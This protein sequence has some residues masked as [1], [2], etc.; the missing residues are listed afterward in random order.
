MRTNRT[1]ILN[2]LL[3]FI[4]FVSCSSPSD[5]TNESHK[6]DESPSY[7]Q[8]KIIRESA[9]IIGEPVRIGGLEVA[10]NDFPED[11]NWDDAGKACKVLGDGWRLPTKDELNLMYLY[12]DRIGGFANNNYW[13]SKDYQ[14]TFAWFQF[15]YDGFQDVS[16][17]S[18]L[19]FV[20]AVR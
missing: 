16:V 10:Q 12:K 17:K 11:I 20:R 7:A 4:L 18:N 13:S 14:T 3:I 9:K 5:S 15:F 19:N 2:T 6:S 1:L 8:I